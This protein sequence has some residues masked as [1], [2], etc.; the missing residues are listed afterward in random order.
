MPALIVAADPTDRLR[1]RPERVRVP[2]ARVHRGSSG[3]PGPRALGYDQAVILLCYDGSADAAAAIDRAAELMPGR[4]AIV[5]CVWEGLAEVIARSGGGFAAAPLDFEAID[6]ESE[7]AGL[8]RAQEGAERARRG[9]LEAEARTRQRDATV[10]ETILH[11]AAESDAAA[12]VLGSRGLTGIK[13][14]VLGSVSHAVLQ[15][16]DRPVVVVPS[17]EIAAKRLAQL[18]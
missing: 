9:G 1:G 2:A 12:I 4:D 10:W 13:S 17:P 6:S 7:R 14:L 3:E 11:E 18:G 16:A 5:L 8:E 15:H